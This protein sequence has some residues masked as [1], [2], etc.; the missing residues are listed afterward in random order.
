MSKNE[1]EQ[2]DKKPIN[3]RTNI[4]CFLQQNILMCVFV[5]KIIQLKVHFNVGQKV[6]FKTTEITTGNGFNGP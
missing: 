2:G 5:Y 4:N 3:L 1:R 6:L